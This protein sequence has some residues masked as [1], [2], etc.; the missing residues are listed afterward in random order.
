MNTLEEILSYP[1]GEA[2]ELFG[3]PMSCPEVAHHVGGAYFRFWPAKNIARCHGATCSRG[4]WNI[5]DLVMHYEVLEFPQAVKL[6]SDKLGLLGDFKPMPARVS[7]AQKQKVTINT[8]AQYRQILFKLEK[9]PG[10]RAEWRQDKVDFASSLYF[11]DEIML[12]ANQFYE[13]EGRAIPVESALITHKAGYLNEIN[14]RDNKLGAWVCINPVNGEHKTVEKVSDS[15]HIAYSKVSKSATDVTRYSYLLVESDTMSIDQQYSWLKASGL[16]ILCLTHSGGKSLHA[17]VLIDAANE[18]EYKE[19]STKVYE[20]LF[21][22]GFAEDKGNLNANRYTRM[23]GVL[24]NG[25]AQYLIDTSD[26][27][28]I[29][30]I[31]SW[32]KWMTVKEEVT[33]E[34]EIN[35]AELWDLS[36]KTA[37]AFDELEME[38][39]LRKF[40]QQRLA[41][42]VDLTSGE[43]VGC[44]L[45]GNTG[46]VSTVGQETYYPCI[47][48]GLDCT[49]LHICKSLIQA[50]ELAKKHGEAIYYWAYEAE[51]LEIWPVLKSAF[52]RIFIYTEGDQDYINAAE[53]FKCLNE[54]KKSGGNYS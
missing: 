33:Q 29:A 24:R 32:L 40:K 22:A 15:R 12:I 18:K 37:S 36:E 31:H 51:C 46:K 8:P 7:R 25:K 23:P 53:Y 38:V 50:E 35:A 16:P 54:D 30:D 45:A 2:L 21:G 26:W 5:V 34:L 3:Y 39:S 43:I 28:M 42:F 9:T 1:F 44:C 13:S 11:V 49:D 17:I 10:P 6:I 52:E 41:P 14:L 47:Y 19:I 4:S 20:A 27:P 48:A